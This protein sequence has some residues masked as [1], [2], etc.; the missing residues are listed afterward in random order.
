MSIQQVAVDAFGNAL[1]ESIAGANGQ[2]SRSDDLDA[3]LVLNDNF[4]GVDV[5]G[6]VPMVNGRHFSQDAQARQAG[7]D[8]LGIRQMTPQAPAAAP[9]VDSDNWDL[10]G[11]PRSVG[12]AGR[13]ASR[14]AWGIAASLAG[15]GA[16]NAEINQVKNQLLTLNPELANGAES[17]QRYYVPDADTPANVALARG[18]DRAYAA[19]LQARAEAQAQR[20]ADAAQAATYRNENYGNEGRQ[21][22]Q[23]RA[24]DIAFVANMFGKSS[25]LPAT[26]APPGQWS[27][28]EQSSPV[29]RGTTIE[30]VRAGGIDVRG[31]PSSF[32]AQGMEFGSLPGQQLTPFQRELGGFAQDIPKMPGNI[33]VGAAEAGMNLLWGA[34]PGAPAY[35]P[36][37]D[38]LRAPYGSPASPY[39]ELGLGLGTAALSRV[40]TQGS[41]NSIVSENASSAIFGARGPT[42]GRTFDPLEAGGPLRD[43][44]MDRLKVTDRGI[45]VVIKHT[46]RFGPDEANAFMVNRL[47]QISSGKLEASAYD[48]NYYSHELR[49]YTRYRR[50]GW[51]TGQPADMMNA[52]NL[53]NNTHTATL[54]E[55]RLRDGQ[56]YHPSAPQ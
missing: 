24:D 52:R 36:Y 14:G 25:A 3:F 5:N 9:Y 4:S 51:E 22:M 46:S 47:R 54:E 56:L 34:I 29:E 32:A 42:S 19:Q 53:W 28:A 16:S 6:G 26:V 38:S 45:D 35:V 49:E 33:V 20:T 30:Q 31:G 55:Y 12:V 11:T 13:E 10:M 2:S 48:L 1:G 39:A 15:T 50:M 17:G 40:N 23:A 37:L 44:S 7:L 41:G 18:A 27:V 21:S 8:P 43:L